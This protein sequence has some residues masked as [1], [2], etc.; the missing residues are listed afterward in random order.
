MLNSE[1]R[2]MT[3]YPATRH[4]WLSGDPGFSKLTVGGEE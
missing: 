2:V 4:L 3:K 1:E